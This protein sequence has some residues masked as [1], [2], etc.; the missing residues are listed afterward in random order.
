MKTTDYISETFIE[1][2][3][4]AQSF[5]RSECIKMQ[6]KAVYIGI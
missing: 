6:R 3:M 5:S 2:K 4:R 1:S